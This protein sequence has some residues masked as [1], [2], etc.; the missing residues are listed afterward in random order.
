MY[1]KTSLHS[2]LWIFKNKH[3]LKKISLK[4]RLNPKRKQIRDYVYRVTCYWKQSK[5]ILIIHIVYKTWSLPCSCFEEVWFAVHQFR[6]EFRHFFLHF[7][8]F[9]VEPLSDVAEFCVDHAEIAQF[10]R[11]VSFHTISHFA[12]DKKA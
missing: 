3:Q 8:H 10:N 2:R 6:S 5:K 4:F 9:S 11:D 7:S 12:L 1:L